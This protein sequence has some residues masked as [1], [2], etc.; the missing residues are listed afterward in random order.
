LAAEAVE[1]GSPTCFSHHFSVTYHFPDDVVLIFHSQKAIPAV[2]DEIRCRIF[3]SE[4]V[5]YSDYFG[6]VWIRGKNAF[7]G[8]S[9]GGL[10]KNGAV[11]NIVEFYRAVSRGDC[12]K[13]TVAP[14]VRSKL[15]SVLGRAAAYRGEVVTW[16]K[17]IRSSERLEPDF[18]DLVE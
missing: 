6:D 14:S 1:A 10:Y 9:T 16:D 2:K 3:G 17:M 7:R 15:T 8:G 4:G 5:A 11:A 13:P 12:S 18:S